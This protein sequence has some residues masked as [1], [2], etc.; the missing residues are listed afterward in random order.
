M[1]NEAAIGAARARSTIDFV[2]IFCAD[3][4][5]AKETNG[6]VALSET[7][8]HVSRIFIMFCN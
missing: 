2:V 3:R 7:F 1:V 8:A 6:D 5:K 4:S